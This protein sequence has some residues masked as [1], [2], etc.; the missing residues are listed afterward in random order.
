MTFP[1]KKIYV[2]IVGKSSTDALPKR[3]D[4]PTAYH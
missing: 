1:N 2:A 4:D 3:P